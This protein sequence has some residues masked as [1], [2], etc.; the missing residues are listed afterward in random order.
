[1]S[2]SGSSV[3][4]HELEAFHR[5]VEQHLG[6]TGELVAFGVSRTLRLDLRG[7]HV[8]VGTNGSYLWVTADLRWDTF[9]ESTLLTY[10]PEDSYNR[11]KMLEDGS[12]PVKTGDP[13]FDRAYLLLGGAA[14]AVAAALTPQARRVLLEFADLRPEVR[15]TDFGGDPLKVAHRVHVRSEPDLR[16]TGYGSSFV[17]LGTERF[18]P[19]HAVAVVERLTT[20]AER[21]EAILS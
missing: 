4:A 8:E 11:A 6:V 15:G 7:R 5:E 9:P 10:A 19:E 18:T 17:R 3:N 13:A 14:D 2:K 16:L 12:I 1:M 20:C 21:L